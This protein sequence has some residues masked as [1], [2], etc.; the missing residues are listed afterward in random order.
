MRDIIEKILREYT[1]NLNEGSKRVKIHPRTQ[2][3]LEYM[4]DILYKSWKEK[5]DEVPKKGEIYVEDTTGDYSMVPIYY[6]SE[7]EGQAAVY[8]I[9]DEKER[10][11]YNVFIVVNPDN[12]MVP[13]KKSIY[14]VLYHEVQHLMDLNSTS[15]IS[16]KK[17][18]DYNPR[19]PEKYYGHPFE[20][21][22]YANEVLEGVVREY[23]ELIGRYTEEELLNS[24]D[25][26]LD[27]FSKSGQGDEILKKVMFSVSS[28]EVSDKD[29]PHVLHLLGL[30][31]IHN[32]KQ[33]K[34]F[35]S[36]L[37]STVNEI[38]G[39]IKQQY[40]NEVVELTERKMSKSYCEKTSC[41]DMG[42]SQKASCKQYKDCYR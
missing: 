36:M 26:L 42:F 8:S 19:V 12:S 33:W 3:D 39:H 25:T 13:T 11:L 24:V 30:L 17:I 40:K 7:F 6:L 21:R 4:S 22:A 28:E 10:N 37:Y 29:M 9:N 31:K 20:F 14:N 27:F 41:K 16:K 5:D 32:P 38:K 23:R 18:G 34:D 15:K 35:L 1:E 2:S